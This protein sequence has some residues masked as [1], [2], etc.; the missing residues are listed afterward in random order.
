MTQ[1]KP[2]SLWGKGV[3][4]AYGTFVL[5]MLGI[6]AFAAYQHF[7]LVE[8]DYY[9]KGLE[10]QHRL[11]GSARTRTEQKQPVISFTSDLKQIQICFPHSE[12]ADVMKGTILFFRPSTAAYDIRDSLTLD[13]S[14][15]QTIMDTRLMPGYWRVKID[16][17]E[18]SQQY[19]YEQQLFLETE[20]GR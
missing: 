20:Q 2:K 4:I 18:N 11:D 3:W 12:A 1:Q 17:I 13:A 16:W 8:P 15:C 9:E 14:G 5:F 19:Y 7:D 6:V 10:Y